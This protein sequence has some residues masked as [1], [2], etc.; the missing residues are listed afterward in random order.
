MGLALQMYVG[1]NAQ[2]YPYG[3]FSPAPTVD[4][5]F[6]WE[7]ALEPY[8]PLK[9]TNASYHCPSYKGLVGFWKDAS[10]VGSYGYNRNGTSFA[11]RVGPPQE[12]WLL[13]LA[14]SPK[15]PS[16]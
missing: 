3:Y 6:W 9:W 8:Y 13:G 11:P 15:H 7:N 10:F 16:P 1:E 4:G 5:I 14:A 2:K 12:D